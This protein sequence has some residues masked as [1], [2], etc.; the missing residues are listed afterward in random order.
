M[1]RRA[2]QLATLSGRHGIQTLPR[3]VADFEILIHGV[4]A[5]HKVQ[6]CWDT[7]QSQ[8]I[9]PALAA[10]VEERWSEALQLA[11][12][13][14]QRLFDCDLIGLRGLTARQANLNLYTQAST[15]KQYIGTNR[16]LPTLTEAFG[17]KVPLAN[18]LA[19]C[20][21]LRSVDGFLLIGQ[22]SQATYDHPGYFHVPGGHIELARH[23]C[24]RRVNIERA[25]RDE[26]EEELAIAP[27]NVKNIVC[28]GVIRDGN[29]KK[30]ELL[31]AADLQYRHGD[32][33]APANEEH[34]RIFWLRD[35]S[36]ALFTFVRQRNHQLVPAGKACLLH[37][38][39]YRYGNDWYAR[40]ARILRM[41]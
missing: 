28:T 12:R 21:C 14:G 4:W 32:L 1:G 11:S 41:A 23:R 15:Y 34:R 37:Y 3:R 9:T 38:G 19:L 16:S 29:S 6:A 39:R 30:P 27:Q 35:T 13:H 36:R 2:E 5:L 40:T 20:V 22:R 10:F 18:P 33:H 26:L 24:G 7:P 25:M 8:K 17:Q 31:L